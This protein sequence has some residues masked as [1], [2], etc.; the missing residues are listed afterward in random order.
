M[1]TLNRIRRVSVILLK[2]ERVFYFCIKLYFPLRGVLFTPWHVQLCV[3]FS[4]IQRNLSSLLLFLNISTAR[5]LTFHESVNCSY[6]TRC[7]ATTTRKA[8]VL[9]IHKW[10]A[11][12][13][14][15]EVKLHLYVVAF[16]SLPHG[17]ELAYR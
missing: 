8:E 1:K 16:V 2:E 14:Y 15:F 17:F 10:L 7:V 3:S 13:L 5:F 12:V 9:P 11:L 4:D 6:K